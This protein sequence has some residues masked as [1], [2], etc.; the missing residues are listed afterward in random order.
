MLAS[1]YIFSIISSII[2]AGIINKMRNRLIKEVDNSTFILELPAYR[3][4]K[5]KVVLSNTIKSTTA[6]FKKAGPVRLVLSLLLWMLTSFPNI[7]PI[8]DK[9]GLSEIEAMS[10]I[11]A[12]RL[13]TS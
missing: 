6:Y 2:I 5:F 1:I 7:N 9:A 12:E 11:K 3:T 8:V 13:S 10:L 4:P